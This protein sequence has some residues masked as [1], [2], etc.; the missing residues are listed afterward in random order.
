[1]RR[2]RLHEIEWQSPPTR[3]LMQ[4][5]TPSRSVCIIAAVRQCPAC[6][7]R[8][9]EELKQSLG[10]EASGKF[11]LQSEFCTSRS[12]ICSEATGCKA[13]TS[14]GTGGSRPRTTSKTMAASMQSRGRC[15]ESIR[16]A[17]ASFPQC[18]LLQ[19]RN[20][21]KSLCAPSWAVRS[22]ACSS[23]EGCRCQM[24]HSVWCLC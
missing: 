12:Q 15:C 11:K 17:L 8:C 16:R 4:R 21:W 23:A 20:V 9:H 19:S 2:C 6:R 22:L 13:K 14:H 1:M 5:Q 7:V 3:G 18:G 24:S 10:L